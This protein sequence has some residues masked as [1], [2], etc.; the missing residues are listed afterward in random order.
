MTAAASV[1]GNPG[2]PLN[3]AIDGQTVCKTMQWNQGG[4]DYI[5]V[6][7]VDHALSQHGIVAGFWNQALSLRGRRFA[8]DVIEAPA[9]FIRQNTAYVPA[10][11]LTDVLSQA[12]FGVNL[13]SN[14]LE[15]QSQAPKA[16]IRKF[17]YP[18]DAMLAIA[19]D[20]DHQTLRKFNLVH[21]FL[22]THMKTPMGWGLGLDISDSFFM[23]NGTNLSGYTDYGK[24]P[25]SDM[26]T[27]F[28]GTSQQ[29]Y[30]GNV[31]DHY[32]Q[33]GWMD[34]MHSLGDFNGTSPNTTEFNRS[35]AQQAVKTLTKHGDVLH[36]WI[37]HGNASN[38][39][40]FGD[41][42]H[43]SFYNYQ[44]GAN[45]WS[46]YYIT[47]WMIPYGIQ[48]VWADGTNDQFG[49]HSD[50]YPMTLP[51]GRK[52][53]GFQRYTNDGYT[54]S[55]YPNYVWS[56]YGLP[57]SLSRENLNH[58]IQMHGYVVVAQHFSS[59]NTK[60]PFD[61]PAIHALVRLKN[62]YTSGKILVARTSRLLQYNEMQQGLVYHTFTQ[63]GE[64]VIDI[65]Q[66]NDPVL[67]NYVPDVTQ[68]KGAT[69]YVTDP[70]KTQIE[71]AGTPIP[72]SELQTNPSD[73]VGP[74]ISVKWF[75]PDTT[76]YAISPPGI[77]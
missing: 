25:L 32:I 18:Y 35:L 73:G 17:P 67:G 34:S 45:P 71:I 59:S 38:V 26:M 40:N 76:N 15:I 24:V 30:A 46:K 61:Y 55:G 20:S 29:I 77:Y 23:Y 10:S 21:E 2:N 6:W 64:T 5:P 16:A 62:Y 8:M 63:N 43:G 47:N 7:Y 68:V 70:A 65:T 66:V 9:P 4:V 49:L 69:F 22:N 51:D 44:Q 39:D 41:Y 42:G 14:A 72:A 56:P 19:A 12:G 27:Y 54:K 36:V 3:I 31:I 33:S 75:A 53:W 48:Y 74:S 37:D 57:I 11:E 13:T 58:L 50:I 1:S 60:Y 28:K 52:V